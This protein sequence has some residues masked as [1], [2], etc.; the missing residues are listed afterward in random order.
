MLNH[1]TPPL[2]AVLARSVLREDADFH[3]FQMLEAAIHQFKE[4]GNTAQGQVML[5]ALARYA[6]AHA[7]TQRAQL[8]TAQ[9]AL[10]LDRSEPVYEED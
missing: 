5:T 10:R 7:P 3:T 4:W 9:I 8:Q 6:A 1:P 2:F